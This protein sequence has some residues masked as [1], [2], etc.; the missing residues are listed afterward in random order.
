MSWRKF[1]VA[2]ALAAQSLRAVAADPAAACAAEDDDRARLACYDKLFRPPP[3]PSAELTPPAV[4]RPGEPPPA[5]SASNAAAAAPASAMSRL[6]ELE[7][8]DK[9]GT[10]LVKTYLP[11]FVLPLHV[12]SHLDRAPSSPTHPASPSNDTYHHAEVKLQI[13]LRAKV[14]Q[15]V[16]LPDAD[17]WFAYTQ[18]SMWQLWDRADSAPFRSTDYQPEAIYAV[19]IPQTAAALPGGWRWRMLQA[20][21]AHQSNGQSDPLS[22]SWNRAFLGAGFE[23]G[24]VGLQVRAMHRLP[25]GGPD[26]NPDLTHYIGG[27]EAVLSWLPG[28]SIA[29]LTWRTGL[30][31][32]RGSLQLDWTY[33]VDSEQPLGLR[34]YLQPFSG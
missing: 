30:S 9:H 22:R 12:T 17:L 26:D 29:A 5:A 6:W 34:W 16:L 18:R 8:A 3:A 25:E 24:D 4:T 1:H 14:A 20:G 7:R 32:R 15:S 23:R 27:G 28:L 33:P 21:V 10:F 11:N 31:L 19:P 2:L 13:S